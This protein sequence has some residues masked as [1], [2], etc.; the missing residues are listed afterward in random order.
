M[1]AEPPDCTVGLTRSAGLVRDYFG[2]TQKL[3]TP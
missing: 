3:T 1:T 2:T